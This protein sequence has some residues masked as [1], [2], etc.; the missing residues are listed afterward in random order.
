MFDFLKKVFKFILDG[1]G[2]MLEGLVLVIRDLGRIGY[3]VV[4]ALVTVILAVSPELRQS[5]QSIFGNLQ[6][7]DFGLTREILD[8]CPSGFSYVL[9]EA[10]PWYW[11]G[12][13]WNT[14]V[15]TVVIVI[16]YRGVCWLFR[17]V[18]AVL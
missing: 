5:M 3:I 11:V 18:V 2:Y 10:I 1:L 6:V 7:V 9:Q 8:Y 12:K 14:L 15:S 4:A 17:L 16:S 13:F